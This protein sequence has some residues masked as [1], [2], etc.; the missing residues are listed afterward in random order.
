[1]AE[2]VVLFSLNKIITTEANVLFFSG[3]GVVGNILE[4]YF[5]ALIVHA[6]I[7]QTRSRSILSQ[8]TRITFITQI[9]KGHVHGY[10]Q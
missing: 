2:N 7:S 8:T 3:G 1:M 10:K 5:P 6:F 9:N 4:F